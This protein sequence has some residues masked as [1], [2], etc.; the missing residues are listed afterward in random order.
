MINKKL[1]AILAIFCMILSVCAVSANNVNDGNYLDPSEDGHNGA[2][3]PPDN[4]H[5]EQVHAAG[6]DY[7][8]NGNEDGHNGTIIPP[9][10]ARNEE[11]MLNASGHAAGG[12][13]T[14]NNTGNT[15][16][17]HNTTNTTAHT[18]PAT[19]NPIIALLVV[20]AIVGGGAAIVKRKK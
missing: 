7:Y 3:I 13:S 19:G 6:G 5:N 16:N 14:V 8:L 20:T 18:L 17:T 9:D 10:Y 4:S 11:A 15:T 12:V 1:F 2:I